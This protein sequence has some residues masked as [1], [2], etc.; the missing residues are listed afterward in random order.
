VVRRAVLGLETDVAGLVDLLRASEVEVG[1]GAGERLLELAR[2]IERWNMKINLISRKDI[3][4]LV[5]YHFCDAASLL[6]LLRPAGRTAVLDVGGSNGLP[7]L[8]I[9]AISPQVDLVVCDSRRKRKAF[10]DEACAQVGQGTRFELDRVESRGFRAKYDGAFDLI[11]ARAVTHLGLLFRWCTHLLKAGGHLVA[12]KGSRCV[13][14]VTQAESRILGGGGDIIIVAGSPWAEECNPLRLFAII[15]KGAN[16][17]DSVPAC[18][19][20]G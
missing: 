11:V 7:G 13:E 4:R 18:R 1:A 8:V 16:A 15:G 19:C 12:Y 17:R 10:M 9:A 3:A 2:T 6:A 5:R 14:E 20:G